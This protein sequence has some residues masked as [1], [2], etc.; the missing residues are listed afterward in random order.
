MHRARMPFGATHGRDTPATKRLQTN[1]G[2]LFDNPI[3]PRI[4]RIASA[5]FATP[6]RTGI[7]RARH[8]THPGSWNPRRK[9]RPTTAPRRNPWQPPTYG[10]LSRPRPPPRT[11]TTVANAPGANNASPIPQI[12]CATPGSPGEPFLASPGLIP[13]TS[14]SSPHR[15]RKKPTGGRRWALWFAIAGRYLRLADSISPGLFCWRWASSVAMAEIRIPA[16][17]SC[18]VK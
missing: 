8:A 10:K 16:W 17:S 11:R 6:T 7:P 4:P 5:L 1:S 15:P 13:T 9:K 18:G 14:S 12:T 2:Q 3:A